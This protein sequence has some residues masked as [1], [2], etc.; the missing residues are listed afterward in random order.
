MSYMCDP[1]TADAEFALA[2]AKY[3]AITGREQKRDQ[4]VLHYQIR[5]SFAPGETDPETALK[6]GYDLGMR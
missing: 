1:L 6:I 2:K 3:K 5:Q 4:D